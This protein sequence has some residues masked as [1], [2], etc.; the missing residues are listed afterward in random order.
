MRRPTEVTSPVVTAIVALVCRVFGI[1]D[2]DVYT[3]LLII[4][5]FVPAAVTWLVTTIRHT[6][7]P[8]REVAAAN[9]K[10][11]ADA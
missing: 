1:T 4:V 6:D 7:A 5:G 8:S 3:Y 2:Q 11:N 9:E 10:L